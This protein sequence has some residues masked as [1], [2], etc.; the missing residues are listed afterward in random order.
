MKEKITAFIDNLIIYDHILF[1]SVFVVFLLLIILAVLL[2]TKVTLSIVLVLLSV[3]I[4]FLGPTLGYV[5]MH[6][7]LFKNS[8]NISSQKRLNFTKAVV[9]KGTLENESKND[10]KNCKIT[11]S[12]YKVSGN[13]IK[14]YI[15][16]LKPFKNMS[17][18]IDNISRNEIID[19]KIIV[20]PFTYSKDYNISIGAKCK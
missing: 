14:D 8:V 16:K 18:T 6:Q 4:L 1:A 3:L 19:F 12:A 7:Y 10:F 5:K 9:V 15:Y 20:E 11:A 2:R 13:S 17:I